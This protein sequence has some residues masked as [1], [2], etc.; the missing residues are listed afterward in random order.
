M[1]HIFSVIWLQCFNIF[2]LFFVTLA[3]FPSVI[4]NI[5]SADN[6]FNIPTIYFS[7]LLC[8]LLF[9]V[10]AMIGNFLPSLLWHPGIKYLWIAVVLR[11]AFI[12]FFL[13]C[14]FNPSTR[15][16]PVIFKSDYYLFFGCLIL[17]LSSGY[18]SS[19][20]MMESPKLVKDKEYLTTAGMMTALFL[21]VGIFFGINASFLLI[22]LVEQPLF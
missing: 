13:F 12:P 11:F 22:W 20:I 7:S 15:V 10:A 19:L 21:V 1:G 16:W 3:L 6:A 18:F 4:A 8:Y 2:S 9:N 5:E 17:G 14:N